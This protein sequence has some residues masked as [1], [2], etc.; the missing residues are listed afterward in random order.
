MP[1]TN[2]LVSATQSI[3]YNNLITLQDDS[4]GSDVTL[5]TRRVYIRTATNQYLT[6]GQGVSSTPAYT[7]WAYGDATILLDILMEAT[8]PE[9]TVQW[10]A[11]STQMYEFTDTFCF[12]LEQYV[13]ALGLLADQTSSPGVI[14]DTSYYGNFGQFIVNLFCAEA[15]IDPGEDIYSSQNALNKNTLF[16][17]KE[18]F[19]F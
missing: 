12:D 10:F 4:S 3:A 11:G 13:F 2:P 14:Q 6:N 18:A 16:I 9:I 8:S 5:T 17:Q 1:L 15:A 19:Y 7:E